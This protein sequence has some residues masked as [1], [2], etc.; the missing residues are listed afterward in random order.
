[1]AGTCRSSIKTLHEFEQVGSNLLRYE[2]STRYSS[3]PRF[4]SGWA[5]ADSGSHRNRHVGLVTSFTAH[6]LHRYGR[7]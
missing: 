5:L 2:E 1:L 4:R 3:L 7:H 6:V